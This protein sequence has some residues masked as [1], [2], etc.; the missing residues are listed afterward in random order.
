MYAVII[1]YSGHASQCPKKKKL[2]LKKTF[3]QVSKSEIHDFQD[4]ISFNKP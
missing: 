2:A 4:N 1:F 3:F